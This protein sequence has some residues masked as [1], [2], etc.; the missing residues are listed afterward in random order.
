MHEFGVIGYPYSSTPTRTVKSDLEQ[1]GDAELGWGLL[2]AR[3]G[4]VYA[5]SL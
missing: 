2:G 5:L 4:E 3:C 1:E